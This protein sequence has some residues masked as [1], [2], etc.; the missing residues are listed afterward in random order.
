MKGFTRGMKTVPASH[1]NHRGAEARRTHRNNHVRKQLCAVSEP[2]AA[3][4]LPCTRS[5]FSEQN[6][7]IS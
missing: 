6:Q 3:L 4:R 1:V 2:L 7:E 5:L